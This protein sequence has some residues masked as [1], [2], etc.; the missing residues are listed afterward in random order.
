VQAAGRFELELLTPPDAVVAGLRTV[1]LVFACACLLVYA[2]WVDLLHRKSAGV[3]WIAAALCFLWC[4]LGLFI[5]A[6]RF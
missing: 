1:A 5:R 2:V 4:V 6:V 3:A